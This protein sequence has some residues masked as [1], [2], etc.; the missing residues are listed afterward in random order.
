MALVTDSS[1]LRAA[2]QRAGETASAALENVLVD[3]LG[4]RP[5]EAARIVAA[6]HVQRGIIRTAARFA[7]REDETLQQ[8][9]LAL[10]VGAKLTGKFRGYVKQS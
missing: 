9:L 1:A 4:S 2:A 7:K 8:L 3:V 10:G 5:R 6:E